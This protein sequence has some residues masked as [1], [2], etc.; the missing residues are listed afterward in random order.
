MDTPRINVKVKD[1]LFL[2]IFGEENKDNLLCLFNALNGTDYTDPEDLELY[3]IEDVIYMNMKNDV[4]CMV[5]SHLQLYEHQSTFNPNMPLRGFMYFSRMFE[6]YKT[7]ASLNIY[8]SKLQKI[9]TPQ[10][11]VFY[12]GNEEAPDRLDLKLSDAFI[13]PVRTGT[14][15]WTAVMLN[16]NAGHNKE[17]FDKCKP[18]YEYSVFVDKVKKGIA[19]GKPKEEAINEAVQW[20][21]THDVMAEYLKIHKAEVTDMMLTEY[22]EEQTMNSFYAEG[23]AEGMAEGRAEERKQLLDKIF[24]LGLSSDVMNKI[25]SGIGLSV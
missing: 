7:K 22:N 9:P 15:E 4:S 3:T 8:S 24:S 17:L 21:I 5:D 11:Y 18:L 23:K 10:F 6:R 19:E 16:I 20:C 12:N 2:K 1:R 13:H 14:F 25:Q